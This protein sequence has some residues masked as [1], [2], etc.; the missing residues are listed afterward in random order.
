MVV[1]SDDND[2]DDEYGDMGGS[3]LDMTMIAPASK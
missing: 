1:Y 3:L 2:S